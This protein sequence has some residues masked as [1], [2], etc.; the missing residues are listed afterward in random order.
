MKSFKLLPVSAAVLGVFAAN[1]FAE[2]A[3]L[4]TVTVTDNQGLK[5]KSNIVTTQKKMKVLKPI[6]VV[7]C[8]MSQQLP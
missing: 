6:Y 2:T 5:V 7:Y 4:D 8:V 1:A 3:V